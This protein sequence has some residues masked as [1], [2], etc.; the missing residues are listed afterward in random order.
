MIDFFKPWTPQAFVKDHEYRKTQHSQNLTRHIKALCCVASA[1]KHLT[2]NTILAF[3]C[4]RWCAHQLR[5]VVVYC[6]M[7]QCDF[8]VWNPREMVFLFIVSDFLCWRCMWAC[9]RVCVCDSEC[10]W[11][12]V[13]GC[14]GSCARRDTAFSRSVVLCACVSICWRAAVGECRLVT[15]YMYLVVWGDYD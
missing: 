15:S 2:E 10:E 11:V 8:D 14:H 3:D 6:N 4:G 13:R 1:T 5:C 7:L 9:V 12:C